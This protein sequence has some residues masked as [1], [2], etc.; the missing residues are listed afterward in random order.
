M[1]KAKTDRAKTNKQTKTNRQIHNHNFSQKL[2][3]VHTKLVKI[4]KINKIEDE[5][6]GR[7]TLPPHNQNK[8]NN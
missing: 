2:I 3:Y 1:Y 4:L 8:N 5:G 6:I 7:Y